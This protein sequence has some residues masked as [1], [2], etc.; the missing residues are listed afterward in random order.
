M[1]ITASEYDEFCSN[2]EDRLVYDCDIGLCCVVLLWKEAT[3][4]KC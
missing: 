3:E 4:K 2:V 1:T